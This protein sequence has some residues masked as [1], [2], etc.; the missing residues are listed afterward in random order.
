MRHFKQYEA[1]YPE[2]RSPF[3]LRNR[4]DLSYEEQRRY[5]F[6][7]SVA[8]SCGSLLGTG[9]HDAGATAW[10]SRLVNFTAIMAG[11]LRVLGGRACM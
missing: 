8:T 2:H 7:E 5:S 3:G 1:L 4:H 9:A 11:L 6:S 10:S